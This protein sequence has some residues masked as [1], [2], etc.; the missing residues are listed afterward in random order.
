MLAVEIS[1]DVPLCSSLHWPWCYSP[2]VRH[3]HRVMNILLS[4]RL[5]IF[6]E[7]ARITRPIAAATLIVRTISAIHKPIPRM[8]Y[9]LSISAVGK[10]MNTLSQS[11]IIES[12]QILLAYGRQHDCF[13]IAAVSVMLLREQLILEKY[14]RQENFNGFANVSLEHTP[15]TLPAIDIGFTVSSFNGTP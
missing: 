12:L 6:I 13:Q 14:P 10:R 2:D 11:T 3:H 8:Y 9:H 4:P 5:H 15:N 1:L 7:F